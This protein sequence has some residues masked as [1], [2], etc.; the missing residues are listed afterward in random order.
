MAYEV[1]K[2]WADLVV[3]IL[4]LQTSTKNRFL[5]LGPAGDAALHGC[6]V[7]DCT[8]KISTHGI[9]LG[10]DTVAGLKKSEAHLKARSVNAKPRAERNNLIVQTLCTIG[11]GLAYVR[12]A[13]VMARQGLDKSHAYGASAIG[14]SPSSTS[15][16]KSNLA[17]ATGVLHRGSPAP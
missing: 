14:A 7:H 3:N 6:R 4:R 15:L 17:V 13:Q 1:A 10:V 12:K 16:Q 2:E 11:A 5:P 8:A 9:H